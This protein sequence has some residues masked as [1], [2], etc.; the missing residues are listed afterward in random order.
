M[1]QTVILLSSSVLLTGQL[2]SRSDR[3]LCVSRG[4]DDGAGGAGVPADPSHPLAVGSL[5][6]APWRCARGR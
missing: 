5:R 3:K 1:K 2:P 4:A 6:V